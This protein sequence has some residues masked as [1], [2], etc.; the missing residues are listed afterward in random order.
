MSR[1]RPPDLAIRSRLKLIRGG[2]WLG[3]AIAVL[4]VLSGGIATALYLARER[5]AALVAE[6]YL[7]QYGI[8][9]T[10]EF[11]VVG[12]GGFVARVR[13]GSPGA[14]EF[15]AEG[16]QVFLGYPAGGAIAGLTPVVRRIR[17]IRPTLTASVDG[18]SLSFG[19][20]QPLIDDVLAQPATSPKPEIVVENGTLLLKTPNGP[21]ALIADAV[22]ANGTLRKLDARV[23][24]AV[25]NGTDFTAHLDGGSLVADAIGNAL[26]VRMALKIAAVSLRGRSARN[27]DLQTG[28]QVQW[29]ADGD[30]YDVT[31]AALD[32]TVRAG[33]WD[34]VFARGG[35]SAAEFQLQD[36]TAALKG[37]ELHVMGRGEISSRGA[38]VHYFDA[39]AAS[40]RSKDSI[41]ALALEVSPAGWNMKA[42]IHT[43]GEGLGIGYPIAG[44]RVSLASA[45][46]QLDGS[47]ATGPARFRADA[48]GTLTA[49]GALPRHQLTL[50][51][52]RASLDGSFAID[53][54]QSSFGFRT[55]LSASTSLPAAAALGFARAMPGIDENNASLLANALRSTTITTG[56]MTIRHAG[57]GLRIDLRGPIV[58]GG[59]DGARFELQSSGPR[60]LADSHNGQIAG[61][62]VLDAS[63]GSFAQLHLDV[64]DY[65]YAV[66][67]RRPGMVAQMQIRTALDYGSFRKVQL[68]GRGT[69]KLSAGD[70]SF[71]LDD[72][73]DAGFNSFAVAGNVLLTKATI[74][75][76]GT[77]QHPVIIA[78]QNGWSIDGRVEQSSVTFPAAG[79]AA[80][81]I[82]ADVRLTGKGAEISS[83][84][85]SLIQANLSDLAKDPR[86]HPVSASGALKA[87]GSDW[88]G[89]LKIATQNRV[90]ADVTLHHSLA[91]GTGEADIDARGLNFQ[92]NTFLPEAIAPSLAEFGSRV[93]GRADF[94]GRIGWSR[95][96]VGPG[97]GRL[98]LTNVEFQSRAGMVRQTNADLTF[99]SLLPIVLHP[100]QTV[101]IGR[102]E[103]VV[104]LDNV[105][106]TFSY[107]P[108]AFRL[109]H[110]TAEVAGGRVSLDPFEYKFV[111]DGTTGGTLRLQG[112]DPMPLIAA[113]GL[114]NRVRVTARIDGDIPFTTGPGGLRFADGRI[115]A[116]GP[117]SLAIK[118]EA[119]T[120]SV[121]MGAGAA[122]PPNAIQDFAYQA[123]ENLSFKQLEGTVN[124]RP[125]GWLGILLHVKGQHDPAVG[126]EP[127]IGVFDLLRGHAFDK[128]LPL[129]KGT[130]IE[131]TL[132]TSV[133]FDELL[134]SWFGGFRESAG[135]GRAP[136]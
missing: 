23:R 34:A 97:N 41:S 66:V 104:P 76:C 108:E 94:T 59:G 26:K 127:R 87:S 99:D 36:V 82:G 102:V 9:S 79:T 49:N 39:E 63:D 78:G 81:N 27:V 116:T 19:A 8:N 28:G 5:V 65:R 95:S 68:A 88:K 10:I 84:T 20:L 42:D 86:F 113:A 101:T 74:R 124:S 105:V 54:A 40:V 90:L 67:N 92:P 114:Q 121:G 13:A 122:A 31:I 56:E 103:M 12:W 55:S 126:G 11:A 22:I 133:N 50:R 35:Q 6:K 80:A 115:A 130:P 136:N 62:F 129:P 89:G 61:G 16:V 77:A 128:P 51:M 58:V 120:A 15:T 53:H 1:N 73:S 132:D 21:V 111:P 91:S 131:L 72:C 25:L 14:P 7:A 71:T 52:L 60:A 3:A 69:A 18:T 17:L 75:L 134:N 45:Q 125:M 64:P 100:S 57:E 112:V 107:T 70:F 44:D 38:G 135:S 83:G 30:K 4:L 123:L 29:K 96:G 93:R 119:L 48:R 98:V 106:T 32:G 117:G 85:V 24:P 118:R 43:I 110:A 37:R 2:R 109:Q 46:L 47:I 33:N